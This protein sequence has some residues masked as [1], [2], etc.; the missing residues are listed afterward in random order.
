MIKNRILESEG[1]YKYEIWGTS[2]LV[3]THDSNIKGISKI[4]QMVNLDNDNDWPIPKM[5]SLEVSDCNF[6]T[7]SDIVKDYMTHGIMEIGVSRNKRS[8][9]DALLNN[10]PDNIPYLGIDINDKSFLNNDDKKIYTI[11]SDSRE[12]EKNISYAS[13]IGLE[14]ISILFIDGFHSLNMVI[15]DWRYTELLSDNGIVILH[16]T[17]Y[18]PPSL[19]IDFIDTNI[20]NVVQLCQLDDDYGISIAYKKN[21]I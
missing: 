18:H 19:F 20:Y 11:V 4:P 1:I 13:N 14:K 15:N 12:Y 9:T 21:D 17:N 6:N 5:C 2:V 8:F 7:I 3:K 16:D 10:K